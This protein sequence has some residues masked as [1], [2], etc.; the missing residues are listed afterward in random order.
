MVTFKQQWDT[1]SALKILQH[2]TVD[3]ELWAEAVEWLLIYGPPEIK[4]MLS[5]ASG[6]AM[7]QSFPDI[8]P[9]GFD[10]NGDPCYSVSQLAE[11][12][13]ISEEEAAQILADKEKRHGTDT[14]VDPKSKYPIQ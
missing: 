14:F 4:K 11:A 9:I 1:E 2:P 3:S 7:Q 10:E 13:G 12:L 6:H 5:E 8:Q